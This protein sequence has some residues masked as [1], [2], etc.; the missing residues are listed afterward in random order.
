MATA[1]QVD[2]EEGLE[3][4]VMRGFESGLTPQQVID[5]LVEH[6]AKVKT[7]ADVRTDQSQ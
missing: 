3:D 4:L 2:F 6:C 5:L 7:M 1:N